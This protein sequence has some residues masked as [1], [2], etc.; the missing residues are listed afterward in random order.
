MITQQILID[1]KDVKIE[2]WKNY[3]NNPCITLWLVDE[4][5]NVSIKLLNVPANIVK[6]INE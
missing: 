5:T 6:I 1:W 2:V 3:I 4:K